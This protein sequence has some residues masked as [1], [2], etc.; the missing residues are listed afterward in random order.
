MVVCAASEVATGR[1]QAGCKQPQEVLSLSLSPSPSA[2]LLVIK[3]PIQLASP[4][5]ADQLPAASPAVAKLISFLVDLPNSSWRRA[6]MYAFMCVCMLGICMCV[7]MHRFMCEWVGL[8]WGWGVYVWLCV[9]CS[10][11]RMPVFCFMTF[12]PSRGS[13]FT[14]ASSPFLCTHLVGGLLGY[15][16]RIG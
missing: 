13:L 8:C 5:K 1:Q 9:V 11:V 15:L 2:Q 4:A 6:V 16:A 14:V 12:P 10:Y 7:S 3:W